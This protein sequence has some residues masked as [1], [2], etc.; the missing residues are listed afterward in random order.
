M[1]GTRGLHAD[2][3]N[4]L[5]DTTGMNTARPAQPR[6]L[7]AHGARL[8]R[9]AASVGPV[10]VASVANSRTVGLLIRHVPCAGVNMLRGTDGT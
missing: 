5:R 9:A 1:L 7:R 8:G 4:R 10:A 2:K 3:R 6:S